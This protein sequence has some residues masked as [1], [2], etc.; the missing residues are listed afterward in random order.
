MAKMATGQ[1]SNPMEDAAGVIEEFR[2]VYADAVAPCLTEAVWEEAAQKRTLKWRSERRIPLRD[3]ATCY[4]QI[5]DGYNEFQPNMIAD[6][7]AA[8]TD[9]GIEATPARE[10]SVAV[11][12]HI[13]VL[14]V[15]EQPLRKRVERFVRKHFEA[16]EVKWQSDESLRIWWD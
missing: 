16:D 2:T 13:P 10:Y 15:E 5:V 14:D 7:H 8:F 1:D 6:L 11:Y 12:L 9:C 4:A 3:A